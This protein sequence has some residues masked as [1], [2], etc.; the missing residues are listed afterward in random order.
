[1]SVPIDSNKDISY[2]L[3]LI[4]VLKYKSLISRSLLNNSKTSPQFFY[5][6]F[7]CND[8]ECIIVNRSLLVYIFVR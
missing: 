3:R 4:Q 1:M 5:N 8:S 6:L 2:L 7:I